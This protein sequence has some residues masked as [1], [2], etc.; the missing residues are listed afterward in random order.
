MPNPTPADPPRR[1]RTSIPRRQ[2]AALCEPR[3]RPKD[4]RASGEAIKHP[5]VSRT[6]SDCIDLRRVAFW[7]AK[8]PGWAH[9]QGR[10]RSACRLTCDRITRPNRRHIAALGSDVRRERNSRYAGTPWVRRT[11]AADG[12]LACTAPSV[13]AARRSVL[14]RRRGRGS[15]DVRGRQGSRLCQ[16]E[17]PGGGSSLSPATA[18]IQGQRRQLGAADGVGRRRSEEDTVHRRQRP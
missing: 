9:S 3:R 7:L 10:T 12:P 14:R 8:T 13:P 17:R 4:L 2:V 6:S 1:I 18:Q 16:L 15:F 11:R 5:D